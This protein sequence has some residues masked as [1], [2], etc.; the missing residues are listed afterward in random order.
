MVSVKR[1][2]VVVAML[3]LSGCSPNSADRRGSGPP[4]EEE[5]TVVIT[6]PEDAEDIQRKAEELNVLL[7]ELKAY[8]TKM[9]GVIEF[10]EIEERRRVI[11]LHIDV[12]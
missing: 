11:V 6:N 10:P 5:E 9:H 3:L 12:K 2:F 8:G 1:M 4:E 7:R